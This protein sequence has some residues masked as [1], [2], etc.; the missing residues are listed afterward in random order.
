M[1]K[2]KPKYERSKLGKLLDERDLTLKEF[3]ALVYERT[4]YIIAITNL[5]NYCTGF[6][7]I[8]SIPI[9]QSFAD[10]LEVSILDIL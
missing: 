7:Q 9:A 8:R 10:T 2:K 5:S 4:G 6:K 1:P 3:A